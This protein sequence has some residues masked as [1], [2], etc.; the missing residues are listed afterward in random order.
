MVQAW[1]AYPGQY[2]ETVQVMSQV[3]GI[4]FPPHPELT[5]M[6]DVWAGAVQRSFYE[7]G[8]VEANLCAA[9]EQIARMLR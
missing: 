2:L 6:L 1:G 4:N 5:R 9:Q 7:E 8:N 3:A